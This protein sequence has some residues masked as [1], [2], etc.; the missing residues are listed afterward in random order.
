MEVS[1]IGRHR[2][3]CSL[4]TLCLLDVALFETIFCFVEI[5]YSTS[6]NIFVAVVCVVRHSKFTGR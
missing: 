2:S 5:K 4:D 1:P 6:N 3:S